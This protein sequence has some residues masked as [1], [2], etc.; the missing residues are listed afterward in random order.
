MAPHAERP[1]MQDVVLDEDD[2][3]ALAPTPD[4]RATG[5]ALVGWSRGHVVRAGA[6][7][8]ALVALALSVLVGLPRWSL[9]HERRVLTAPV[10]LPGAIR[11][12]GGPPAVAWT[13]RGPWSPRTVLAGDTVVV[14]AADVE[15]GTA[16]GLDLVT[17]AVRWR[18]TL[19]GG[20]LGTLRRCLA[21]D[22]G[23]GEAAAV[24]C[25]TEPE[26]SAVRTEPVAGPVVVLDALD[27]RVVAR[28][29]ARGTVA[30][31]VTLGRDLVLPLADESGVAVER[32]DARTGTPVWRAQVLDPPVTVPPQR[33]ALRLGD[34][35]LLV[36]TG[37][38][39]LVLEQATGRA[40]QVVDRGNRPRDHVGLLRDGSVLVGAYGTAGSALMIRTTVYDP[41]GR[42]RFTTRGTVS[43]PRVSDRPEERLYAW[44]SLPGSPFGGR[45]R[46]VSRLTGLELWQ[47]PGPS[48]GVLLELDGVAVLHGAG[49]E[50]GVDAQD[51]EQLW[52][53]Q[54][55]LT[56]SE[57][58]FT[59]G[60]HVVVAR[61]EPGRGTVLEAL[62][63]RDGRTAWEVLLPPGVTRVE[64][65]GTHLVGI[66][67]RLV[68]ALR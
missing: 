3:L 49:F 47:S 48:A 56:S 60:E 50:V 18:T 23:P 22:P 65:I 14:Y 45:V 25:L 26:R 19:P 44:S 8:I 43:E 5:V 16:E 41:G 37:G 9:A 42:E 1:S 39:S 32:S 57:Q 54:V 36:A 46:A 52:R 17:G 29:D 12:L 66:G 11:P 53:R 35:A 61:V 38:T 30:G 21:V 27:G 15:D 51:G 4:L 55:T 28:R 2:V 64:Q 10:E 58:P 68:V 13:T 34:G 67:P 24:V 20:P 7:T 62:S 40:V 33:V 59:D 63:V 6:A 31:A